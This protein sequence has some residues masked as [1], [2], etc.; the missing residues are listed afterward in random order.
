MRLASKGDNRFLPRQENGNP[1]QRDLFELMLV[2][3]TDIPA[4]SLL[5]YE[6]PHEWHGPTQYRFVFH[7][8]LSGLFFDFRFTQRAFGNNMLETD[9]QAERTKWQGQSCDNQQH[10]SYYGLDP[11]KMAEG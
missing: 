7:A 3:G 9:G 8:L 2:N 1:G 5:T 11:G 4:T 10:G 6:D